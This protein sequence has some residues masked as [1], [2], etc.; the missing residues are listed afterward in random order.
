MTRNLLA[1]GVIAAGSL[2]SKSA[3][4]MTFG[5]AFG[6]NCFLRGTKIRTLEGE[7]NVEDIAAGDMLP[8]HFGGARAVQW[9]G[10]YRYRKSDATKPWQ[11]DVRPVR[12]ARSAIAPNVPSRDLYLTQEHCLYVDGV[13]IGAG[14][15]V[16]GT[17]IVVDAAEQWDELEY[18]HIKLECH[19]V[20]YAED[21]AC[22]SLL[23]VGEKAANFADYYRKY[24]EPKA[25]GVL[26][27]PVFQHYRRRDK[28]S[29][30]LRSAA[31]PWV[32]RRSTFDV[33]RDRLEER[34]LTLA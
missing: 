23:N 7:R 20:V 28:V 16:N 8:T 27:A 24:G 4:A 26:C 9:V 12:V 18:F 32:D 5:Q 2:T 31:S 33:V 17:T 15:L 13:L 19:D 25:D 1:I 6:C 11:E 30:R 22:E 29:S 21:L 3:S 14:S 34:A 10:H